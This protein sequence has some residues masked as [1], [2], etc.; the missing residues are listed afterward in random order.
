MAYLPVVWLICAIVAA[1][2]GALNGHENSGFF[3]G[4]LLGPLGLVVVAT[5]AEL[6]HRAAVRSRPSTQH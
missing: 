2:V 3:L 5:R 4:L 1:R 6:L